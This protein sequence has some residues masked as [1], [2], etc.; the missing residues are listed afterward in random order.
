[1]TL[2]MT[3]L[4]TPPGVDLLPLGWFHD[5]HCPTASS[6]TSGIQFA[7]ANGWNTLGPGSSLKEPQQP[8]ANCA[9]HFD[10]LSLVLLRQVE[11]VLPLVSTDIDQGHA[12]RPQD[13]PIIF[14][15]K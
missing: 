2:K 3:A 1:M 7:D 13:L 11:D 15:R 4:S 6:R 8:V 10:V 5:R 12:I 14:D 9:E